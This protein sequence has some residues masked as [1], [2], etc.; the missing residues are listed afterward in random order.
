M[1]MSNKE[2]KEK[3]DALHKQRVQQV[4]KQQASLLAERPLV[5]RT[6]FGTKAAAAQAFEQRLQEQQKRREEILNRP[7]FAQEE[8]KAQRQKRAQVAHRKRVKIFDGWNLWREPEVAEAEQRRRIARRLRRQLRVRLYKIRKNRALLIPY[9]LIL[10][11]FGTGWMVDTMNQLGRQLKER[12]IV[13]MQWEEQ[14]PIMGD[15]VRWIYQERSNEKSK[16]HNMESFV[17]KLKT[18][19]P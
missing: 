16:W 2:R 14:H 11:V 9:L 15:V 8:S 17:K 18:V 4:E 19:E 7:K 13:F 1:Y 3:I 5:D 6:H 10:V 12:P